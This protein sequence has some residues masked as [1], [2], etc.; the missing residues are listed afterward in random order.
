MYN[1]RTFHLHILLFIPLTVFHNLYLAIATDGIN[2]DI[3]KRAGC[4]IFMKIR[5]VKIKIINYSQFFF[6]IL[7]GFYSLSFL[8]Q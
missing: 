3:E 7:K 5:T 1:I 6:S 2:I 8:F 4:K